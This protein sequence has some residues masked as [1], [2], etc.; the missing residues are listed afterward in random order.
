M[1]GGSRISRRPTGLD[2]EP[3][4]WHQL[5]T[6]F[7]CRLQV[8]LDDDDN[9]D[10]VDDWLT[11]DERLL[12][13]DSRHQNAVTHQRGRFHTKLDDPAM[14]LE[15]EK[16]P[17]VTA[18]V[19]FQV[20]TVNPSIHNVN[21]AII[22]PNNANRTMGQVDPIPNPEPTVQP[23]VLR[24][25]TRTRSSPTQFHL[26]DG[27]A[28]KWKNNEVIHLAEHMSTLKWSEND[29]NEIRALLADHDADET[30]MNCQPA[31][32]AMGKKRYDLDTPSYM[33]AMRGANAED[34]W[35]TMKG[36][37]DDSFNANRTM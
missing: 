11:P 1:D 18:Q 7:S 32:S 27:A 5:I 28:S 9:P 6:S 13:D 24:R 14:T 29:M 10:L 25:S 16:V 19:R 31:V 23:S 33:E 26:G 12:R 30:T 35:V 4:T 20:E 8:V 3:D 34:H 37:I 15:R 2:M 21:R 22:A 36:E 17:Q